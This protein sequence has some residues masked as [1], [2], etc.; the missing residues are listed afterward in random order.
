[1]LAGLC[2]RLYAILTSLSFIK[3]SP[4][5]KSLHA[6]WETELDNAKE[7]V[8]KLNIISTNKD[9]EMEVEQE[10]EDTEVKN[11]RL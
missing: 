1:M 7:Y 3:L 11:S 6:D 8:R 5:D 9:R 2:F 10:T 4:T